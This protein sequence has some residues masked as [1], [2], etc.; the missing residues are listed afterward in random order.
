VIPADQVEL[1]LVP[2]QLQREVNHPIAAIGLCPR[3]GI[4]E[5]ESPGVHDAEQR[6][7]AGVELLE[8]ALPRAG[9]AVAIARCSRLGVHEEG[10]VLGTEAGP[11]RETRH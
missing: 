5:P 9:H 1:Q 3:D 6:P 4:L 10:E 2:A 8:D 7:L 11:K